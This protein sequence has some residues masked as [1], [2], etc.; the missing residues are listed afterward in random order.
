MLQN[1]IL[2]HLVQV[3]LLLRSQN[4]ISY[5][6]DLASVQRVVRV[7]HFVQKI[8]ASNTSEQRRGMNGKY[9][10]QKN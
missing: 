5:L 8:C 4:H 6:A 10:F 9:P 1:L 3:S 7:Q 2:F